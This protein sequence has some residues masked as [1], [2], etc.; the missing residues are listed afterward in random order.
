ML[1]QQLLDEVK[2]A[3]KAKDKIRLE[4]LRTF[5][6]EVKNIGINEGKELTDEVVIDVCVKAIKQR[7]DSIEQ[8]GK[9]GRQDLVDEEVLKVAILQKYLPQALT[10][11]ELVALIEKVI[12]E[13][14]ASEKKD[15]GLVMKAIQP[16]I[17]G[18][19]DGKVVNQLIQ[20]RLA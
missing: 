6:S 17:K 10:Q 19:A 7:Q 18:K 15:L 5:H 8:F 3:M 16:Q 2:D 13:V 4:T 1:L 12:A 11:E 20:A 9:G 14:G